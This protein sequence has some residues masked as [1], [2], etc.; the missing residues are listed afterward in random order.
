VTLPSGHKVI[1]GAHAADRHGD[2]ALAIRRCLERNGPYQVWYD[3]RAGRWF[4]LCRL[5]DGRWGTWIAEKIS[6]VFH[7]VTAYVKRQ[8][9][10]RQ[11]LEWLTAQGAT[12]VRGSR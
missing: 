6:G 2:D 7:E 8:G 5:P 9:T 1:Y 12:R 11:V 10:W 4:F 3:R